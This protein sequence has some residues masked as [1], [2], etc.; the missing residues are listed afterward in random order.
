[1]GV[2]GRPEGKENVEGDFRELWIA[3]DL[4]MD[5]LYID[6]SQSRERWAQFELTQNKNILTRKEKKKEKHS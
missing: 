5:V 4:D 1:M 2:C 3:K 6:E